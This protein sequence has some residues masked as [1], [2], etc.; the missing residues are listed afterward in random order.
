MNKRMIEQ[1]IYNLNYLYTDYDISLISDTE[2]LSQKT[3]SKL[4]FTCPYFDDSVLKNFKNVEI[5][6]LNF[7]PLNI[8][9]RLIPVLNL[10]RKHE[11]IQYYDYS[12]SNISIV[13]NTI[14]FNIKTP[15]YLPYKC[16]EDELKMLIN[17]KNGDKNENKI[18]ELFD[19]GI[20]HDWKSGDPKTK[21]ITPPRRNKVVQFL[22]KNGFNINIISGW[23]DERDSELGNCKL[24]LNLH[25]QINENENPQSDEVSNIF[26]H[27]RCNRILESGY[28]ILS[29]TSYNL[30]TDFINK[31]SNLRIIN[32]EDFFNLDI[33]KFV[34]NEVR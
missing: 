8:T 16:S 11:F 22:I 13:N 7:E 23:G 34:L 1:Y 6:F 18:K 2:I 31:H 9:H 33:L 24:I 17:Y 28:N 26:E 25:G 4:T 29:E 3:P 14:D 21:T 27:L 20:I 15:I 32:Y 12:K 10:L 19:F 30:D 5:G